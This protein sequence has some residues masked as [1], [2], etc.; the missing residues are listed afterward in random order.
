MHKDKNS[1]IEYLGEDGSKII[2]DPETYYEI[3]LLCIEKYANK[4]K[5][6]SIKILENSSFFKKD[7]FPPKTYNEVALLDNELI[8]DIAMMAVYGDEYW[9]H[10]SYVK[11]E[12]DEYYKWENEIIKEKNLNDEYIDYG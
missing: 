12:F 9:N 11:L 2:F 4:S 8:Y 5:E 10:P 1:V 3:A 6:E 7:N